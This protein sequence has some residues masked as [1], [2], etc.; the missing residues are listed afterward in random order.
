MK[1]KNRPILTIEKGCGRSEQAAHSRGVGL[2]EAGTRP[3]WAS[4]SRL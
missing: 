3:V 2:P 1:I 4:A